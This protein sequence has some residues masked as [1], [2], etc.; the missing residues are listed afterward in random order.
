MHYLYIFMII[1]NTSVYANIPILTC[2]KN[3][4]QLWND[5]AE[6]YNFNAIK[7]TINHCKNNQY[8]GEKYQLLEAKIYFRESDLN[9]SL[10][11]LNKV[12][13]KITMNYYKDIKNTL[14]KSLYLFMLSFSGYLNY[15]IQNWQ[16]SIDDMNKYLE[17]EYDNKCMIV[18]ACAYSEI[19]MYGKSLSTFT[20][21]YNKNKSAMNAFYIAS[22]YAEMGN[23][24]E[25]LYWLQI[26]LSKDKKFKK[27][28]KI[29]INFDKMRNNKFYIELME[30]Y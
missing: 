20:I 6:N 21:A 25:S 12:K 19:A 16:T 5:S 3:F 15:E 29:E 14:N 22:I 24:Q 26:T 11:L 9:K 1:I 10:S 28:I 4:T 7:K 30:K 13:S 17:I 23:I 2:Q 18:L 8:N 27:D